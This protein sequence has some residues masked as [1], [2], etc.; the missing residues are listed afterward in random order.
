MMSSTLMFIVGGCL[1]SAIQLTAGIAI[2]LWLCRGDK[3]AAQRGRQDLLN[4]NLITQRLKALTDEMTC[5]VGE[6]Q[7]KLQQ[8]SD[9]LTAGCDGDG[10]ALAEFV[11]GVIGEVVRANN[12][13]NAKLE[14]AEQRLADQAVEIEAYI[15]RSLTDPLT[16]LPNRREFDERLEERMAGW[17]RRGEIF[18]LLMLD[19]DHFK[20]LNDQHGHLAGDQMLTKLG[21]ALR[22]ALRRDDAV[23]RYGGEEFAM[24]L[25]G[26]SLDSAASAVPR[27]RD[28]VAR[29]GVDHHGAQLKVTVSGGLATIQAGEAAISLIDR[30]DAAL[31]T[32]KSAGRDCAY[33]H[34][35]TKC[36][37]V[38]E[39][40]PKEAARAKAAV[41]IEQAA[42]DGESFG[43]RNGDSQLAEEP[44]HPQTETPVDPAPTSRDELPVLLACDE[45]ISA[46]MVQACEELR[47]YVQQR[48]Q[49]DHPSTTT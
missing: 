40:K 15:S 26:T 7:V 35:G 46:E 47:D 25:P 13:L 14:T 28:T 22:S 38:V 39:A 42:E 33:M 8:A 16:G 23:A 36:R 48:D 1:L 32:A 19:V 45:E 37:P 20:N 43:T 2:G 31:Y 3:A 5:S 41:E 9:V 17:N 27:I 10:E 12:S 11:V 24:I 34:D 21:Q 30:A 18:S 44:R 49:Q 4:A 29:A 6:H